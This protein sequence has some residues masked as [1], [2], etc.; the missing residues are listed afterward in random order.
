VLLKFLIA[1][2]LIFCISCRQNNQNAPTSLF[3]RWILDSTSGR[4]GKMIEGGPREHTEFTLQPNGSFNFK[5]R[6]FDVLGE[7]DGKFRYEQSVEKK[8]ML[9][10]S[11]YSSERKDSVI[12]N[13]SIIILNLTDS[14]LKA[15]EK[16]S[17]TILDSILITQNR[18]NI[19]KKTAPH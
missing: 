2:L 16:E 9:I 5:W 1:L 12:R 18:R 11:I 19:Y 14:F 6:D 8:P 15:Q 3:G 10:F 7:Y 4:G 17:Y 13:D